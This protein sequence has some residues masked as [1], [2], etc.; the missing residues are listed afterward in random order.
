MVSSGW[1]SICAFPLSLIAPSSLEADRTP[2]QIHNEV[3][4]CD[5]FGWSR[6]CHVPRPLT[7]KCVKGYQKP[8]SAVYTT[9]PPPPGW[10]GSLRSD[11]LAFFEAHV[12]GSWHDLAPGETRVHIDHAGLVTFYDRPNTVEPRR[13]SPG[14]GQIAPSL[15][16]DLPNRR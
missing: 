10:R 14:K 4:I 12:S 16:W 1:T 8:I 2:V 5:F 6:G 7:E 9:Q 13:A 15:E 3:M 11:V